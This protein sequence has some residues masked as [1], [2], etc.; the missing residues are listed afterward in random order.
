VPVDASPGQPVFRPLDQPRPP[1]LP[2]R[3]LL[4]RLAT[5]VGEELT[6]QVADA[7]VVGECTCGCSSTQLCTGAAPLPEATVTRLSHDSRVDHLAVSSAGHSLAGSPVDVVLHVNHGRASELEIFDTDAG[8][9]TA[10][11][12]AS[13]SGLTRPEIS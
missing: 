11:D 4:A 2:E 7:V 12:P 8:E 9:G 3:Q 13:I 5:A 10:V 6:A 1:T